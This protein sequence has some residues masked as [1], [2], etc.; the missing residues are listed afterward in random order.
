MRPRA[1]P[2]WWAQAGALCTW[3]PVVVSPFELVGT[4]LLRAQR[5]TERSPNR[6]PDACAPKYVLGRLFVWVFFSEG[7]WSQMRSKQSQNR[8]LCPVPLQAIVS[9]TAGEG[10]F[11]GW[12]EKRA[13]RRQKT[14][15]SIFL[16]FF[17]PHASVV[18]S[19]S[20]PG[21]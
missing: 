7:R 11:R 6:F 19:I 10:V 12:E 5:A 15:D 2:S 17:M 8:N 16:V 18:L 20:G 3:V 4:E 14:E 21:R 1:R 9:E 13:R